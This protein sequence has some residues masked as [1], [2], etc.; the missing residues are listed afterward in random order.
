MKGI[1]VRLNE[2]PFNSLKVNNVFF[3][4]LLINI[5]II[6][7]VYLFELFSQ[8]MDMAHGPLGFGLN[9]KKKFVNLNSDILRIIYIPPENN[10]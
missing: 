3:C 5:M 2:E 10:Q 1:Q 4:L 8:V 6:I 9:C 7:C